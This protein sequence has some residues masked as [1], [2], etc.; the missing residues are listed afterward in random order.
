MFNE[1]WV[2]QIIARWQSLGQPKIRNYAPY[3]T[4][5]LTVDLFF[6]LSIAAGVIGSDRKSNRADIAYLYYLPFAWS[7]RPRT[8]CMFALFHTSCAQTRV[9]SMEATLKNDLRLDEH[10]SALPEE[11]KERGLMVLRRIAR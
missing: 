9:S 11:I 8:T 3:F 2:E 5:V 7:L 4:H 10:Y 1:E 6:Y